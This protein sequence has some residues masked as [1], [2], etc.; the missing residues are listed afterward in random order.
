MAAT[1]DRRASVSPT[2]LPSREG[3]SGARAA[4]ELIG[5]DRRTHERSPDARWRPVH[6]CVEQLPALAVAAQMYAVHRRIAADTGLTGLED[7]RARVQDAAE[8]VVRRLGAAHAALVPSSRR[9]NDLVAH[10][11]G[12]F[13]ALWAFEPDEAMTGLPGILAR[14]LSAALRHRIPDSGG[15]GPALSRAA[16]AALA[17]RLLADSTRGPLGPAGR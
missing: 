12:E 10:H 14:E 9:W 5:T 17:L 15:P 16:G 4:L 7:S 8:G 2:P 6:E 13:E 3:R 11:A 1:L